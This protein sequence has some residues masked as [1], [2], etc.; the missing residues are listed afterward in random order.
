M[1]YYLTT[2]PQNAVP[3]KSWATPKTHTPGSPVKERGHRYFMPETGR[4]MSRDPKGHKANLY[5]GMLNNSIEYV[6]ADGQDESYWPEGK[7]VPLIPSPVPLPKTGGE[8][9]I[10]G[11]AAGSPPLDKGECRIVLVCQPVVIA[12]FST[13]FSHCFLIFD[14]GSDNPT[15]CRGGPGKGNQGAAKT[16]EG[17]KC[18]GAFGPVVTECGDY[19]K[20]FV[21]YEKPGNV[22]R[23][24]AQG[25]AICGMMAC[26][27]SRMEIYGNSCYVYDPLDGPNCNTIAADSM[28]KCGMPRDRLKLPKGVTAPGFDKDLSNKKTCWAK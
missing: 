21:D 27:Q 16:P 8:E 23:V 19:K 13:P 12:G 14:N 18:C 5:C 6:D 28:I 25:A 17:C 15:A 3:P 1:G 10:P 11:L 22:K 2:D 26:A 24:I 7:N 4:W 9:A 20:G